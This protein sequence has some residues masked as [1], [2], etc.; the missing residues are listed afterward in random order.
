MTGKPLN[1]HKLFGQAVRT[2]L[3]VPSYLD[4]G[5]CHNYVYIIY[6]LGVR[7]LANARRAR[8]F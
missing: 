3:Y 5:R 6:I 4:K 1:P 2:K 7:F 8:Q